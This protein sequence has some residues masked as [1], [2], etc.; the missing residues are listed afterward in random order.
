MHVLHHSSWQPETD[1]NYGQVFS[2]WDRLFGTYSDMPRHGYAAMQIGLT[3]MRGERAADF[4]LQVKSP[5]WRSL[6]ELGG[7][8]RPGGAQPS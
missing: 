1:S 3:E 4:W 8:K 2:F 5:A 7:A 6:H